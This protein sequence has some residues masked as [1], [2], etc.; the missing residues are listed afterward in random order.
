[1]SDEQ[2]RWA[3]R[4]RHASAA[5]ASREDQRRAAETARARRIVAAFVAAARAQGMRT[6]RLQVRPFS[7]RGTYRSQVRGWYVRRD[8]TLGVGEDG[9][10]YVLSVPTSLR[11]R[12]LGAH[13]TPSDPPLVAGR[14]GRDG[15]SMALDDLL[16]QRL[17]AGDSFE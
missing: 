11:A 7:G 12:L 4:Q 1:V 17:T 9:Q 5:H 14:G 15:Q 3:Q 13:L 16:R 2:A 8:H 10:F 6:R